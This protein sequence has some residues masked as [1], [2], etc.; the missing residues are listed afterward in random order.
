MPGLEE[1]ERRDDKTGRK[2]VGRCWRGVR[3]ERRARG[4]IRKGREFA[5]GRAG[6]C[7]QRSQK[8]LLLED[9]V[10]V[11]CKARMHV[12]SITSVKESDVDGKTGCTFARPVPLQ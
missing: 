8:L 9:V 2:H 3:E 10:E 4:G 1:S 6:R 11:T 12:T 7:D 5:F